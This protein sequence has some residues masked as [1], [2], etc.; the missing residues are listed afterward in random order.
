MDLTRRLLWSV[1]ASVEDVIK[2]LYGAIAWLGMTNKPVTLQIF[3]WHVYCLAQ[4]SQRSTVGEWLE[5]VRFSKEVVGSTYTI[6][7][8]EGYIRIDAPSE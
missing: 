3:R 5:V 8:C 7:V 6:T 1:V 2:M 4:R